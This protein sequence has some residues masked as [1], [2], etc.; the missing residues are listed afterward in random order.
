MIL[1]IDFGSTSF[2][3]AVYDNELRVLGT[4]GGTLEYEFSEGG[5]VDLPVEMAESAFREAI[6]QALHSASLEAQTIRAVAVTS[7][8][9]TFT[10][11]DK[12]N[13]PKL[14]FLSWQDSRATET[15]A[16]MQSKG[17]LA[18]IAEHASFGELLAALQVSMLVHLRRTDPTL[19]EPIDRIFHL[20]SYFVYLLSKRF[21]I[22]VNLAAMSGMY[23]LDEDAWWP[24]AL[25]ATGLTS[26]QLAD[27]GAVGQVA[28]TTH[29]Q[30][31]DWGLPVGIP[32]VFAGND[33]TAGAYGARLEER[34]G[35]LVTLGTAQVAYVCRETIPGPVLA[36]CRGPYPGGTGY[37]LG[38]DSCGGAIVN[39]AQKILAECATNET[40][41]QKV[42]ESPSGCRGLIFEANLPEQAG[43]W[44]KFG[45]HH[46]TAD[47]ARAVVE[48]LCK[49]MA[50][51]LQLLGVDPSAAPVLVA[52]GGSRSPVWVDILAETLKTTVSRTDADPLTGAA[53][54]GHEAAASAPAV[55]EIRRA[56][57]LPPNHRNSRHAFQS[58]LDFLLCPLPFLFF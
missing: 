31:L 41:F 51:M 29:E 17:V 11:L 13:R 53:R 56:V 7:Q 46:T 24:D 16:A 45:M 48:C 38:A 44:H 32:I 28:A 18:N 6:V 52:G 21:V 43:A 40:F 37:C 35:I 47:F 9:Q 39:W 19:I 57:P 42:A 26:E 5:C 30:A 36:G 34:G 12:D 3:A 49:R 2:K 20:P 14:P 8:A 15:C 27:V 25:R 22:D 50:E 10:I 1:A 58:N 4:G 55:N 33:Q 54:M 23:S